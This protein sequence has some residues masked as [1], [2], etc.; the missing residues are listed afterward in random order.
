MFKE[1]N[2]VTV[3]H[4]LELKGPILWNIRPDDTVFEALRLMAAKEIGVVLVMDGEHLLGILT[5]RD[6]A[7]KVIL[8][9]KASKSTLVKDIMTP[10]YHTIHPDQTVE[11][12]V[13]KM[14]HHNSRYLIVMENDK[15][16]GVIAMGDVFR[17]IVRRQKDDIRRMEDQM[18]TQ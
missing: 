7:R 16:V 9:G 14:T 8:L 13:E 12:C 3:R 4:L 18:L 10:T 15:V 6:Y 17:A 5:E 11:E 1:S 2:P